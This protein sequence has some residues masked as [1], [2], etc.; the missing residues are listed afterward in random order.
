MLVN[1]VLW[2]AYLV[3]H[4]MGQSRFP[5]KPLEVI[6]HLQSRR[7]RTMVRHAYRTVPYYRET[8]DRLGLK[9]EDLQNAEDLAKLPLIEPS[10]LQRHPEYFISTA[11]PMSAYLRLRTAG[12]T[13]DPRSV[14]HTPAAIFQNAAH[15]ERERSIITS[16]VVGG[17]VIAKQ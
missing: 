4:M 9:V 8:M 13:G 1:R 12:S 17:S 15:G 5:F 6:K 10:Q 14:Y 16:L 2:N 7:V 11:R 3:Y